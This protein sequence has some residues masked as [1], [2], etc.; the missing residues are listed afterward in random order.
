MKLWKTILIFTS[1]FACIVFADSWEIQSPDKQV[2]INIQNSPNLSYAVHYGDR[3][4]LK[5]S[6]ITLLMN[7]HSAMGE[8][9]S[10]VKAETR[11]GDEVW[12][13]VV[14]RHKQIRDWYNELTL[15]FKESVGTGREIVIT[16]RAYND[17]AVFRYEFPQQ[18][19]MKEVVL[20]D[21]KTEFVFASDW[22][23][24][25][26]TQNGFKGPQEYE[27]WPG[28]L[29][30]AK[31]DSYIGIPL[32]VQAASD[33]YVAIAEADIT[34]WAGMWLEGKGT[35]NSDGSVTIRTKPARY[36]TDWVVKRTLPARSPWRVIMLGRR[37]GD[38]VESEVI[39]NLNPPCAIEDT[40][41]IRPG[42]MAWDHWWSGDVKMDTAT[43]KQ[44]IQ[45]AADMGWEYQLIDWQWYGPFN[46]PEAD[47]TKVNPAVDMDEV[48]RFAA[49][50][51]VKLWVWMYWADVEHNEA[52][53][54]AFPLYQQWGIAGVKIDFMDRDDQWMVNW[55]RKIVEAAAQNHLMVNFHG[56]YKPDGMRRT[57]PNYITQE[58]VLGNEYN[59]WSERVTPEHK[60][61]LPFTRM[62]V[63][64]MDFTPGG[65]IN[66]AKGQF[67]TGIPAKTQGTRANELALMVVY[68][69]PLACICDHPDH[70]RN[71]T[72]ADFLKIVPTVWDD[73]KVLD[74]QIGD[75]I[76]MARQS[77]RRWFVG[78][79]TDW[80]ART[81]TIPLR[82]LPDGK[83][84][85]EIW[86]DAADSDI[87]AEHLEKENKTVNS[88]DD[89]AIRMSP[90]GGC[91][92]IL[93]PLTSPQ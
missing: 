76:I 90:G 66:C 2:K 78:A 51:D 1:F 88:R 15:Y 80:T 44:Y 74:G 86:K 32:V 50:K 22:N 8:N 17:A 35:A 73:T 23:A 67:K 16:F 87:N 11:S 77:G 9:L 18:A 60:A 47:I 27:F 41:W 54:K 7:D 30:A 65:F 62:L 25:L 20:K 56:A 55:Y 92:M 93:E 34:D 72:G 91:V 84:R 28:K 59:K 6:A 14:G 13:P 61:T 37:P 71:E 75:Y 31:S 10:V 4:I 79:I 19:A 70:Y 53:K 68:D 82:F 46:K 45:L 63:G 39:L 52:Y 24:W 36:Q 64:P 85:A 38:L 58:G 5:N 81:V 29:S 69:S 89:L 40:S 26:G 57:W 83:F 21:E 33:A 49:E 12:K 42:R 48:R 43:I 3:E